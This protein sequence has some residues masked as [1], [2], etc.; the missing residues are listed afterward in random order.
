MLFRWS[1]VALEH[2]LSHN[3]RVLG[4]VVRLYKPQLTAKV[5]LGRTV[6]YLKL[7]VKYKLKFKLPALLVPFD[8]ELIKR[9]IFQ[10]CAISFDV[11]RHLCSH[12]F[13]KNRVKQSSLKNKEK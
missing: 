4:L 3:A 12:V 2:C 7:S 9:T 10:N 8:V 5:V 1:I 6:L 11:I 13:G